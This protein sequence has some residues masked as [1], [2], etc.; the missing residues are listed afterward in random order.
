[1][2]IGSLP[3]FGTRLLSVVNPL[4][5]PSGR[6]LS[7]PRS[8]TLLLRTKDLISSTL[9]ILT[10]SWYIL[11]TSSSESALSQKATLAMRPAAAKRSGDPRIIRELSACQTL[12]SDAC[13]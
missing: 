13:V 3:P 12:V 6:S 2:R 8:P 4:D 10:A 11:R 5:P 1:M 9:I 7:V